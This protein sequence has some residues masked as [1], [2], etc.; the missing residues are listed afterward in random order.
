MTIT[1]RSVAS[2]AMSV[3]PA[4]GA[5]SFSLRWPSLRSLL[6]FPVRRTR[7]PHIDRRARAGALFTTVLGT[8][9]SR[10]TSAHA[11]APTVFRSRSRAA[12]SRQPSFP[13]AS[14]AAAML[15]CGFPPATLMPPAMG[16]CALDLVAAAGAAR[17]RRLL[18]GAA[19][20]RGRDRPDC[21]RQ[22]VG[23]VLN[24]QCTIDWDYPSLHPVLT[25]RSRSRS[26]P[27]LWPW[28]TTQ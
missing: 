15:T 14:A 23:S 4:S 9:S 5:G 24:Y 7:S 3:S 20:G 21:G 25:D 10:P 26:S 11:P 12:A 27:P 2:L 18:Q 28:G 8:S 22:R 6:S 16:G 13:A 17:G 1:A 19:G